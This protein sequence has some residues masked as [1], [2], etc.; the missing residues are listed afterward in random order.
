[1]SI[2]W[3]AD[4]PDNP[5]QPLPVQCGITG[6]GFANYM[7]MEWHGEGRNVLSEQ[8]DIWVRGHVMGK[9][10]FCGFD[11][12]TAL[13]MTNEFLANPPAPR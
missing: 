2:P 8:F 6:D 1:M 4:H 7:R 11:D 12:A 5:F 13:R 10:K 9:F 3:Y